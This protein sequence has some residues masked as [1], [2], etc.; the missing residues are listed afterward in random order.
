M[1]L[2]EY[3]LLRSVIVIYINDSRKNEW[4]LQG[5]TMQHTLKISGKGNITPFRILP[6]T[7]RN[8][9]PRNNKRM[10]CPHGQLG[11]ITIQNKYKFPKQYP[12]NMIRSRIISVGQI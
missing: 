11:E 1:Y 7:F 10:P 6:N 4:I 12:K 5:K 8:N 3:I 9:I 2:N